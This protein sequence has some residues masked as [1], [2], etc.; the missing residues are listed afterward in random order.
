MKSFWKFKFIKENGS[1]SEI[2][3][4]GCDK[5]PTLKGTL[6]RDSGK[7]GM[8][9]LRSEDK[10]WQDWKEMIEEKMETTLYAWKVFDNQRW[11]VDQ[12]LACSKIF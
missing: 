4:L 11:N 1:H 10:D 6:P 5:L 3:I 2:G 7:L 12:G 9:S 8:R